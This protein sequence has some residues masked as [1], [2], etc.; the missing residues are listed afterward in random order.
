MNLIFE[1]HKSLVLGRNESFKDLA[2][3]HLAF[4]YSNLAL[5]GVKAC[6]ILDVHVEKSWPD[7]MDRFHH[8]RS[9]AYRVTDIDAATHSRVHI[10]HRLH[11]IQRR[12]NRQ[13]PGP[14]APDPSED[15]PSCPCS[16]DRKD[17]AAS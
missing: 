5:L 4:T 10:L 14:R 2:H 8:V 9:R 15:G 13:A 6:Q 7:L 12:C 16:S 1:I 17:S 3:R 11:H